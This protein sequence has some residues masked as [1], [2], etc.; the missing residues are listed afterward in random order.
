M[1]EVAPKPKYSE[2]DDEFFTALHAAAM[3]GDEEKIFTLLD[4]GADPT[5]RDG[6]GR[7]PFYV[8]SSQRARDAFRRWRG[9]NE[10]A[11]DWQAA[12][13]PEGLTDEMEQRRKEKEKE[14]KKKQKD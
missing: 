14:K 6:K 12:N 5:S 8:C 4:E 11:W 10:D 1:G 3:V 13:V 7:V 9:A 2:E